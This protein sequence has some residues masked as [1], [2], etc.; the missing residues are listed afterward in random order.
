MQDSAC[1]GGYI[2]A[3]TP[4]LAGWS[5]WNKIDLLVGDV[6]RYHYHIQGVVGLITHVILAGV[7]DPNSRLKRFARFFGVMCDLFGLMFE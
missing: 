7:H 6:L 1:T 3:G 5:R 2:A 4:H